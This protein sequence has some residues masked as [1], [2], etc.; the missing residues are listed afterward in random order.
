MKFRK[1]MLLLTLALLMFWPQRALAAKKKNTWVEK[2]QNVYYLNSEGKK[3]KGITKIGRKT[4]YFDGHGIQRT[5]WQKINGNYYFFRVQNGKKGYMFFSRTVNGVE[6]TA[7]GKA[8]LTTYSRKKLDVLV[9]ANKILE[10]ATKPLD[11][12]EQKLRA[13]FEYTIKVFRYK[14]SPKFYKTTYWECDYALDMF[15]GGHGNCYAYGAAFA[16]LGNAVGFT[17]SAISSASHGWA[18]VRGNVFDPSWEIT[19]KKHDYY[20]LDY[21]MSGKDGRPNY[22][23]ARYYVRKI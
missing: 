12:K 16:F 1:T 5:G 22:R 10:S 15:D 2:N 7:S 4:F 11:T 9:K 14:G 13:L 20:D 3:A 21:D 18:E 23:K 6:L 8:K 17:S 19:D